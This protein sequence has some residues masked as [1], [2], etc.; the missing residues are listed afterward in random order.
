M[1]SLDVCLFDTRVCM[2][3]YKIPFY[4]LKVSLE[5]IQEKRKIFYEILK[6]HMYMCTRVIISRDPVCVVMNV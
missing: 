4:G 1:Q 6:V 3:A 5:N 2:N